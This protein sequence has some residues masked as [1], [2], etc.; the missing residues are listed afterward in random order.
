MFMSLEFIREMRKTAAVK[1]D[2]TT[3]IFP[4]LQKT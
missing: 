3:E 4:N 2:I 1:N